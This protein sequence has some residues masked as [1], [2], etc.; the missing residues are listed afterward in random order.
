[1]T[2]SWRLRGYVVEQCIGRGASSEVWRAR[3]AA[4]G[5]AV[6]LKRIAL[7]P[8]AGAGQRRDVGA[9][10]ALL[11]ALDHAHLVRLHAVAPADDALVLV[12][13]LADGGSLA[14][15]LRSR[16]RLTPG[17][18]ITAV[19]PIGAALA[20]LHDEGVVHGDV[21][22]AN[23]LFTAGGSALLADVG[24]AR[25]TG[26]DRDAASTPA[27]VDPSVAAGCVP[28]PP[29]DVFMLA[30]VALHALTGAPAWPAS[31]GAQALAQAARGELGDVAQRLAQASVPA[32]M[33][34]VLTKALAVDPQ[35]RG[36][37]ADLALDLRHSGTPT[38]VELLAG[39]RTARHDA[40]RQQGAQAAPPGAGRY[41]PRHAATPVRPDVARPDVVALRAAVRERRRERL[42]RRTPAP[43]PGRPA[44]ERPARLSGVDD[45]AVPPTRM[46]GSRPRPSVPAPRRRRPSARVLV[47]V[48]AVLVGLAA[49]AAGTVWAGARPDARRPQQ[50]KVSA[51]SG[52]S[53]P[54]SQ[55]QSSSRVATHSPE[56]VR[57]RGRG[58]VRAGVVAGSPATSAAAA[59][60][61]L[62][63]LRATA[64]ATRDAT[65]LRRVYASSALL[66]ADA[67]QLR[68]TVPAGCGLAGVRTAYAQVRV[69][70][71][72]ATRVVVTARAT[73]AA[74]R[75]M[76]AG[77]QRGSAGGAG[78][79][80]LR[81]ELVRAST[82]MQ[83]SAL[84]AA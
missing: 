81:L 79:T 7:P 77:R 53:V 31:D 48:L 16:G 63:R 49:A 37:A 2:G 57:P 4:S 80:S 75:L 32:P 54:V 52:T 30:A 33:I 47:V 15:L 9:E 73:L 64:F 50:G 67:A 72:G 36:T 41:G 24:V 51:S 19:A 58:P 39:R 35:R 11:T 38:A 84:R 76:C 70:S 55:A 20:Y 18:V 56:P 78:P 10:A 46:V 12:L 27:Y 71:A 17:E 43:D 13:D 5:E 22:A 25:L 3:V 74:S 40:G 14:D 23:I 8:D 62:D 29:S 83:I 60:D 59:L 65:V 42:A 68:R 82:G 45:A 66:A 61:A 6:A 69:L 21:S 1:M 44:F 34:R 26:D 28:G